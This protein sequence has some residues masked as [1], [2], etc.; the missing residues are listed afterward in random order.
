MSDTIAA[1]ATARGA[2]CISIV[3]LSGKKAGVIMSGMFRPAVKREKYDSHRLMYGWAIDGDGNTLDEVLAV[4]MRAPFTY[5]R[6]EVV[7]IHCHGG[8]RCAEAVLGRALELGARMAEPGEFTRRAFLNGR[9]DLSRA[10]AV[11]QLIGANAQAAA[12]ASLRQL[13]GGVSGFVNQVSKELTGLLALIEAHTGG[14]TLLSHRGRDEPLIAVYD[15][16]AA[17]RILPLIAEGG[18]PVRALPDLASA[19]RVVY[20]G[21]E[22]HPEVPA[23]YGAEYGGTGFGSFDDD[24]Y[25]AA[26]MYTPQPSS[27]DAPRIGRR[28]QREKSRRFGSPRAKSVLMGSTTAWLRQEEAGPA[29]ESPQAYRPFPG[30]HPQ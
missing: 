2:G 17:E 7:E 29:K 20:E 5:T 12:R 13:E 8:R 14:T 27:K 23:G 10:E 9:I 3:R 1:I 19:R 21:P 11:M 4:I 26:P 24:A 30:S 22:A 25:H 15:C 28:V 6:E 16:A 18:A